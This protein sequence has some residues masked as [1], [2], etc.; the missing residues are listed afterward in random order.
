MKKCL[1]ILS[2]A[3]LLTGCSNNSISRS[4]PSIEHE[5]TVDQFSYNVDDIKNYLKKEIEFAE[6]IYVGAKSNEKCNISVDLDDKHHSYK[7]YY[8]DFAKSVI[9][10]AKKISKE[11]DIPNMFIDITFYSTKG[12]VTGWTTNNFGATGLFSEYIE[13]ANYRNTELYSL[14][15]LIEYSNKYKDE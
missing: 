14:N 8:G 6:N 13:A 3:F 10:A 9:D 2:L 7:M 11:Y 15:D 5:T 4:Q 1:V 12:A